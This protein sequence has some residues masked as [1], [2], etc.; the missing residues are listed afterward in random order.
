MIYGIRFGTWIEVR[1]SSKPPKKTKTKAALS[2]KK[3]VKDT[4]EANTYV[5]GKV[6]GYLQYDQFV[7]ATRKML[8]RGE[9]VKVTPSKVDELIRRLQWTSG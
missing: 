3:G 5:G 7:M 4:L 1:E 2:R 8:G 6:I 9:M